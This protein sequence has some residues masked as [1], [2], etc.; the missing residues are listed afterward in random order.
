[1]TVA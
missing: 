1:V